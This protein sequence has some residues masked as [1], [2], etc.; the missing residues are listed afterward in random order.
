MR[1]LADTVHTHGQSAYAFISQAKER[2]AVHLRRGG[3]GH[4]HPQART[5]GMMDQSIQIW[6]L[7]R[8]STRHDQ[9]RLGKQARQLINEM[10]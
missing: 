6:A 1:S 8:I 2:P 9:E 10:A 3:G 5:N 7:E 4:R